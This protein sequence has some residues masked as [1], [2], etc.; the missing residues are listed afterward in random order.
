MAKQ[1]T[2]YDELIL[3]EPTSAARVY[4]FWCE[5]WDEATAYRLAC[6]AYSNNEEY[7]RLKRSLGR[8]RK[9]VR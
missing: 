5:W 9:E 2:S 1:P 3:D 6:L 7:M 4:R 8:K